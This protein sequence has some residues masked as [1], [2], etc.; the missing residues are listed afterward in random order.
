MKREAV[1]QTTLGIRSSVIYDR[2]TQKILV[3]FV[4][5]VSLQMT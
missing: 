3:K 4:Q 2:T 5:F 1:T